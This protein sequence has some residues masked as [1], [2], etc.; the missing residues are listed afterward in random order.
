MNLFANARA[1]A[2]VAGVAGIFCIGSANAAFIWSL[3]G[4]NQGANGIVS[5]APGATTIDFNAPGVAIGGDPSTAFVTYVGGGVVQNN[6]GLHAAPSGDT[7]NFFSVGP[8][9]SDPATI[10]FGGLVRYFGFNLSSPDSYNTVTFYRGNTV[11]ATY[12]GT[13]LATLLSFVADGLQTASFFLNVNV[14]DPSQYFDRVEMGSSC[15]G[16]C[17]S[18]NAFE[19]DN[20]AYIA[21]VPEPATCAMTLAGLGL[22][23]WSR[24]TKQKAA[25]L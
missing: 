9:T 23:G 21:A 16:A 24:R 2:A 4:T 10:T 22:L 25:R 8:S 7:S 13:N 15:N 12:S 5:S 3:G 1:L 6:A 18:T 14:D 20:H 17:A 11:E 19:T